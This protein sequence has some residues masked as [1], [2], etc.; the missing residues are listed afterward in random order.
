MFRTIKLKL[1]YDTSLLETGMQFREACQMV[2]DYGFSE[3]VFNKNKLNRATYKSIRREI[4]TLPSALIQTARDAA[5]ESLKQT[6]LK[7]RIHR[8]SLT[9]RYDR[10]TFKFYPDSHTISLTTV[11]GRLVFPIAHSPLIE[12][13]RGEYTNAQLHIDTNQRKMSVMVQVEVPDKVV[14][15]KVETKKDVKVL[16]ID[17][18]IKNAA[19]LSNN[20]F[21]NSGELRSIKGRYRHNRSEL[22]HAG[23][24]SAHRKLKELS[25]RDTVRAVHKSCYVKK[26]CRSS[27][28][29]NS[30]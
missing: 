25:G 13:Y 4:P 29:C 14:E 10:R 12:K 19:V 11:R 20:M 2:L 17:R 3:H 15:T 26:D 21:F 8:K 5:S 9:V 7:K 6:K 16:G 1:P 22:Q 23:T 30:S 18:G 24:R 28:Q 27:I